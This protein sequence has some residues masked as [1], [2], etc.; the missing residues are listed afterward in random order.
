MEENTLAI[1]SADI[2]RTLWE[3]CV[4]GAP[5]VVITLD[6]RGVYQAR[7]VSM[8][9]DSVTLDLLTEP[10]EGTFSPDS[11]C[12]VSFHLG[13]RAG[14]FLATVRELVPPR[15][16]PQAHSL[17]LNLPR[18]VI[19]GETRR[20]F[21]LPV[22]QDLGVNVTLVDERGGQLTPRLLDISL[23]GMLVEFP[24]GQDPEFE[25]GTSVRAEIRHRNHN[26]RLQ[27]EIRRR[28]RRQ[29]GI[30]FV[31]ILQEGN[32]DPPEALRTIL[33]AIEAR[34]QEERARTKPAPG[35][36]RR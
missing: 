27:G 23:G 10:A 33:K 14:I 4:N 8:S 11:V 3:F 22:A 20:T 1:D 15:A 35:R 26:V 30:L 32:I 12:S 7:F 31:D 28:E 34:W 21:R 36:G 13:N 19:R 16:A 5:A 17:V 24:I 2:S 25:S 29:Y 9:K 18:L 6:E